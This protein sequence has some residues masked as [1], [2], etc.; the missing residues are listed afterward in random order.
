MGI[1]QNQSLPSDPEVWTPENFQA[2]KT[3]LKIVYLLF[4]TFKYLSKPTNIINNPSTP[5]YFNTNFANEIDESFSTIINE[6]HAVN[7]KRFRFT[8]I[9]EFCK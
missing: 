9:T 8:S 7:R 2:L 5:F 1:A 3:T 4:V 6:E